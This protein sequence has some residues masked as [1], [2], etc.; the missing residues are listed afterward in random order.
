MG[1]K[2]TTGVKMKITDEQH[3]EIISKLRTH[4]EGL[5]LQISS[6]IH[7]DGGEVHFWFLISK[8]DNIKKIISIFLDASMIYIR[9]SNE[10]EWWCSFIEKADGNEIWWA[11]LDDDEIRNWSE[12]WEIDADPM[13]TPIQSPD[14]FD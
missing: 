3:K 9:E 6:Q 1:E 8:P 13:M 14:V 12:D 7:Y 10:T 2:I 4:G 11:T 5:W